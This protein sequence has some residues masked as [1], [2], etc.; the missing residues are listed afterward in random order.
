MTSV[1][2][3]SL[4]SGKQH[5][6]EI[7][8]GFF[9]VLAI[10]FIRQQRNELVRVGSVLHNSNAAWIVGGLLLTLVYILLQGLMY[11]YSFR[12]V[13]KKVPLLLLVKLFLK[14]NFISVFLPGGGIT[15]LAFFT[16]EI[17]SQ[18][19]SKTKINF[20]SYIYG[21]LGIASLIVVALPVLIYNGIRSSGNK[22]EWIALFSLAIIVGIIVWA[23][24]SVWRKGFL[25]DQIVKWSPEF[26]VVLTELTSQRF[27]VK[28]LLGALLFSVLIEFTGMFHLFTAMKTLGLNASIEA[29]VTGYVIATLFFC[30]SPFLRGLGAVEVSLTFLLTRYGFTNIEAIAITLLYRFFEFW[31]PM[32]A[33]LVSFIFNKGNI[34]LRIFPSVLILLMGIVNIVS[35]LTP[36][37][38]SR[39]KMIHEFLPVEAIHASNDLVLIVGVLLIITAAF[40]LRGLKNAW[41]F[42]MLLSAASLVGHLTKAIDYEEAMLALFVMI[43]LLFTRRQYYIKGNKSTQSFGLGAAFI[44]FV[45]VIVYGIIGFYLLDKKHFGIDFSLPHSIKSTLDNFLLLNFID[46]APKTRF[47]VAFLRSLNFLG[48]GSL[49][50]LVYS[51]VRPLTIDKSQTDLDNEKAKSLIEKYGCSSVDYFKTYFDKVLYFGSSVEGFIAYR[52]AENFAVVLDEPVCENSAT[53]KTEILKEFETFCYRNALKPSYYRV[54]EL[55]VDLFNQLGK[56]TLIIGQEA[57]VDLKQFSLEGKD[58]KSMRNALN[59]VSKKGFIT[60]VYE[61]PIKEGLIQKL[62]LVSDE[63]LESMNRQEMVFSQGMFDWDELKNQTIIT[64]E[65]AGEKVV[66]FLNIIP[67]YAKGEA[68]YDM[69]RKTN[70]APG[71]N[72]DVLIVELITYLK[73]KGYSHLNMGLAPLSGIEK[74]KDI[75]ERTIKFAYEKIQQFRHYRGLRDFK[76]K[77]DPDWQNKYLVYEHHFDLLQLPLALTKVMRP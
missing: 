2:K 65:T 15:S 59:S 31:A 58:K 16:K 24:I 29:S 47:A 30:I 26:E 38:R 27:L 56:K 77:F 61:A 45:A 69:I 46:L 49:A 7:L 42:A 62:K 10:Y 57:I 76:E 9:I 71:G 25:Y 74:A 43:V 34:I 14:R 37:L 53:K 12:V 3:R 75:P 72:M 1:L 6:T 20:A 4:K 67:D 51:F 35:V 39:M 52:V 32:A 33:G 68:T 18:T 66:A 22:S 5:F 23:S 50:F 13:S 44:V 63:W 70:D 21:V 41:Y 64:L 19:V 73:N 60:K 28:P 40:L 17:E 54:D 48:I 36:A 8:A 55:R 11:Q